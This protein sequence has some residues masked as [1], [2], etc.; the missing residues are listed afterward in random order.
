MKGRPLKGGDLVGPA[1]ARARSGASMKGRPLTGGDSAPRRAVRGVPA[2]MKGR[3]L[4][5]GDP[6]SR[7]STPA[8]TDASMKGRPLRGGDRPSCGRRRSVDVPR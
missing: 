5:G 6:V 8:P 7:T 4:R 3:P 2:S 1:H